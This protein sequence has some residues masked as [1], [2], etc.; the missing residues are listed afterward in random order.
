MEAAAAVGFLR[1]GASAPRRHDEP[2][3]PVFARPRIEKG[4]STIFEAHCSYSPEKLLNAT[5]QS[6]VG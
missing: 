4:A 2:D 5:A 1:E 3:W 6:S